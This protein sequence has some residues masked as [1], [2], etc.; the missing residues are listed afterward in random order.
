MLNIYPEALERQYLSE[1]GSPKPNNFWMMDFHASLV[2]HW[3]GS[4]R[5][6]KNDLFK[7]PFTCSDKFY[8]FGNDL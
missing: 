4:Q 3:Q 1:T 5:T 6:M 8:Y 2:K 7:R